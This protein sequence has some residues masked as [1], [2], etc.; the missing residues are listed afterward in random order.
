MNWLADLLG[1]LDRPDIQVEMNV[2]FLEF[3][4]SPF[5]TTTIQVI[6]ES[7]DKLRVS[8]QVTTPVTGRERKEEVFQIWE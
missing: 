2:E 6:H 5:G 8:V 7:R 1:K 3:D 4:R